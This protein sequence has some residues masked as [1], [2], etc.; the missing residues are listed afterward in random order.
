[1]TL[2]SYLFVSISDVLSGQ[3]WRGRRSGCG[4]PDVIGAKAAVTAKSVT[5]HPRAIQTIRDRLA[6][7]RQMICS[8]VR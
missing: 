6:R 3:V 2:R 1:M 5:Q 8:E 7:H 4:N